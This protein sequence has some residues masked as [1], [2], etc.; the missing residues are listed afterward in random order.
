MYRCECEHDFFTKLPVL[1]HDRLFLKG[2]MAMK[3]Q[4][5]PAFCPTISWLECHGQRL[6]FGLMNEVISLVLWSAVFHS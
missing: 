2:L 5:V 4:C 3:W 1:L 6:E